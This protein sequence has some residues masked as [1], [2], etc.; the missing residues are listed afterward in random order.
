MLGGL[1]LFDALA[2][3]VIAWRRYDGSLP[4]ALAIRS[5]LWLPGAAVL[6]FIML[7]IYFRRTTPTRRAAGQKLMLFGLLWLI[8]YDACFAAAYVGWIPG[9]ILLAL[10]P[11]AWLSVQLMRWWSQILT[12]SQRPQYQRAGRTDDKVAT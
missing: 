3:A 12:L 2:I 8:I 5:T 7:G 9:L 10:L 11:V 4:E 1:A 6:L